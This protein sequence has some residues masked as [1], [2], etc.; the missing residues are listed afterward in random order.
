MHK[1]PL[2]IP[3]KSADSVNKIAAHIYNEI[4]VIKKN[5]Y[6]SAKLRWMNLEPVMQ[7]EVRQRLYIDA[8]IWNIE[9]WD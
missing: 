4:L 5:G 8:Y 1:N 3:V 7:S 2:G 9:K 6:E